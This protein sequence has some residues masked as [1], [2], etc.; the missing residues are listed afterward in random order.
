MNKLFTILFLFVI[1]TLKGQTYWQQEVNYKISVSLNDEKHSLHALEEIKYTNNSPYTL[2]YIYMHLWPNAYKDNNTMFARQKVRDGSDEFFFAKDDERGWIDELDFEVDGKQVVPI[3]DE[4]YIDI[5]K[6][7]L[8]TPLLPKQTIKI[9]TPFRVMLPK[10]FSRLG[11][12]EQSYQIT[13][14]YPK[15]AVFDQTGWHPMPYLDQGEFYSEFGSFEV[16]ITLPDNYVVG[17]T[18]VLQ[19]ESEKEWLL[20]RVDQNVLE[21]SV[22]P[23][24]SNK[25]T[26]KYKQDNI[27]DFAWFADKHYN[28]AKGEVELPHSGNKVD[29]WYMYTSRYEKTRETGLQD[30]IDATYYYSK[31]VGDYPY[32]SVTAV[33]GALGAGGGM[34][35][36]MITVTEPSAIVHE[37]GHNWFYG[38]LGSNERD[39]GWMDEGMNSFFEDKT[40]IAQAKA[41]KDTATK[42]EEKAKGSISVS[43]SN[44][45]K[46]S[47]ELL[48]TRNLNQPLHYTS[49]AYHSANYL[50]QLYQKPVILMKYLQDY[51][52][53]EL[54]IKCFHEYY[55]SWKFKHPHVENMQK[56]FEN[57]SG[58]NL[59]WLFRSII[60]NNVNPNVRISK[61]YK[62]KRGFDATFFSENGMPIK[63]NLLDNKKEI[64]SSKW[65]EFKSNKTSVYFNTKANKIAIDDENMIFESMSDKFVRKNGPLKRLRLPQINLLFPREKINRSGVGVLPSVGANSVDGFL[66]GL[67]LYNNGIRSKKINYTLVPMYGMKSG[68]LTGLAKV[69]YYFYPHRDFYVTNVSGTAQRFSNYE[70]YGLNL[71]HWSKV[72]MFDISWNSKFKLENSYV[73]SI[74]GDS[75]QRSD[76]FTEI[77]YQLY[78]KDAIR[79]FKFYPTFGIYTNNEFDDNVINTSIELFTSYKFTPNDNIGLR[80]FAGSMSQLGT[81]SQYQFGLSNG[82][83]Y[84]KN[85]YHY[86]RAGLNTN[87]TFSNGQDGG[88][89]AYENIATDWMVTSNLTLDIPKLPFSVYYDGGIIPNDFRWGTG[90]SLN[91]KEDLVEINFPIAGTNYINTTPEDASDFGKSIRIMLKIPLKSANEI[92][93][94]KI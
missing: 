64:I 43:L 70:K 71:S 18:G 39:F 29:C 73:N 61:V 80:V 45:Q 12:V 35:Y 78:H 37:V 40:Y 11:H 21:K 83:D 26:L 41:K 54:F 88:F 13:Q 51:L 79:E 85:Y 34:E 60:K 46:I 27:H 9:T 17:A 69:D 36:P 86:D 56:V 59:E 22:I 19:N 16:D 1:I 90:L 87:Q 28:I 44:M 14:W 66:A 75:I 57:V 23:S 47:S 65:V 72:E 30:I 6:L 10:T 7:K 8:N 42:K 53:E 15:P 68:A 94:D 24:S 74:A 20:D 84:V 48:E 76:I 3:E 93:W 4:K 25:K 58:K 92:A 2:D 31:Y 49:N 52:G 82:L 55:D 38:I 77:K 33:T 67:A 5:V 32:S 89:R 63:A 50:V 91:I 81:G 62:N